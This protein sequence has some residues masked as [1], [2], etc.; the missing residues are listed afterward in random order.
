MFIASVESREPE[1]ISGEMVGAINA[2]PSSVPKLATNTG[3][4]EVDLIKM[5]VLIRTWSTVQKRRPANLLLP[6][7]MQRRPAHAKP[8]FN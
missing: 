3:S 2:G 8:D 4:Q 1:N 5:E 6:E 7:D